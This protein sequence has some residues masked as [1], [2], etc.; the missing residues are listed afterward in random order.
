MKLLLNVNLKLKR[1]FISNVIHLDKASNSRH[2][3]S[4]EF[5]L[6]LHY[7]LFGESGF[8][9][10]FILIENKAF[11]SGTLQIMPTSSPSTEELGRYPKVNKY[12]V[13]KSSPFLK[14]KSSLKKEVL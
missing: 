7:S 8:Y 12:K 13:S 4:N 10:I 3:Y 2:K 9:L 1:V 14:N 11:L 6:R 5:A